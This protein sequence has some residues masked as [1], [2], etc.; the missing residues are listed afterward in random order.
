MDRKSLTIILLSIALMTA[1]YPLT[2]YFFP[3]IPLKTNQV[4][5]ATAPGSLT[6]LGGTGAV[7]TATVAS[8]NAAVAGMQ[9]NAPAGPE[10]TVVLENEDA[11]YTFSSVG[12]GI[13]LIELKKYPRYVGC[14]DNLPTNQL[15]ALNQKAP[16]PVL[17]ILYG[18]NVLPEAGYTLTKSGQTVRAE[19]LVGE[20][21]FLVKE[22]VLSTNYLVKAT[23]RYE[24]RGTTAALVPERQVVIGTATPI[25]HHDETLTLGVEWFDGDATAKVTEDWFL[26]RTLGCFP[27]TPREVYTAGAGSNVVWGAVHN[28]FFTIVGVP[29]RPAGQLIG[30]RIDLPAPTKAELAENAMLALKP[31]GYQTGLLFPPFSIPAQAGLEQKF[32]LFAGPKEYQTL[33]KLPRDMDRAMGF[34]AW[35]GVFAK[36]LLLSMNKIHSWGVSYGISIIIITVIIKLLF[37]PLTNASTK[38]MKRMGALQPQ[39]KAIQEKYKEDPRKMQMKM[40]EFMKE[41]KVNPVGG[42]LPLLLQIP[43]FIGFYQMLQSAIELRGASF[44]WACDLSQPDTVLTVLGFPI[45]ILPLLMGATMLW[46]SSLTPMSPGMDPMQQK[47]L[48]YMPLMMV[49]FLYNFSAGLTLYWTVQNLLSILQMK[50]TNPNPAIPSAG[51]ATPAPATLRPAP[52]KK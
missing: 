49:V 3:P 29:E 24:N 26:N 7:L 42:C 34:G 31:H 13:K 35:F 33:A 40:M 9:T 36:G 8:T 37:W 51:A 32:D 1:W 22:F 52:K 14:H 25:D 10:Q 38:S 20:N 18:N 27:G 15:A 39:M 47:M 50:L 2:N 30:R 6:N 17:G 44:L 43:V 19:K 12:G 41:N 46:Q 5:N 11:K 16:V 21:L 28:R 45:N 4:T 48:K 23:I